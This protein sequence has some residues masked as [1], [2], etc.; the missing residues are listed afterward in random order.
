MLE[1]SRLS[2]AAIES[3]TT[4]VASTVI[5]A[6]RNRGKKWKTKVG[7]SSVCSPFCAFQQA[8]TCRPCYTTVTQNIPV[9]TTHLLFMTARLMTSLPHRS[10]Q[11]ANGSP[12]VWRAR[13]L[14]SRLQFRNST[15]EERWRTLSRLAI[16]KRPVQVTKGHPHCIVT[17][18]WTGFRTDTITTHGHP[19]F[20]A[21]E[22]RRGHL[23]VCDL[24]P[25][26]TSFGTV[27]Q[28]ER[29]HRATCLSTR[30]TQPSFAT[31]ARLVTSPAS[32][33][34]HQRSALSAQMCKEIVNVTGARVKDSARR[35][36]ADSSRSSIG[37]AVS[38]PVRFR[39][40]LLKEVV[41]SLNLLLVSSRTV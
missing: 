13:L 24:A 5:L 14:D 18:E 16:T 38:D 37:T 7:I 20:D 35:G 39:S 40:P 28:W 41:P 19:A 2:A 6:H 11:S 8:D 32:S 34:L 22:L 26:T 27:G 15:G 25:L 21:Q 29:R 10:L 33:I 9:P 30:S 12:R 17:S 31:T 23:L 1:A 3:P 36:I 4:F